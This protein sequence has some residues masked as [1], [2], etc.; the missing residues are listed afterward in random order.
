MLV[1]SELEDSPEALTMACCIVTG[2]AARLFGIWTLLASALRFA[3]AVDIHNKTLYHLTFLSFI[4]ALG[5]FVSEV[6]LYN[7]ARLT[8]GVCAPLI[9]SSISIIMMAVGY[10]LPGPQAVDDSN[11]TPLLA[12]KAKFS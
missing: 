12:K 7:T 6:C 11:E 10:C 4:L 2:L 8:L 5:H 1:E 9:V 3:C